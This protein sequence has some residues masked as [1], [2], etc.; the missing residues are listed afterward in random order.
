M[1]T[2]GQILVETLIQSGIKQIYG[3]PGV[4]LDWLYNAL[5]DYRDQ[6]RTIHARHEQGAAYMALGH[7]LATGEVSA[8]NVVPGPGL[9]NASAALATA[10]GLN[11]KVMCI[12]GQVPLKHHNKGRGMLHELWCQTEILQGLT[13]WCCKVESAAH[14]AQQMQQA[15]WNLNNG[16]PVPVG[17]EVFPEALSETADYVAPASL[18]KQELADAKIDEAVELISQSNRS[19]IFVGGGAVDASEELLEFAEHI[20]APVFSYRTGKGIVPDSH[21]LGHCLPA[22]HKLWKECDLCILVGSH[23]RMPLMKWGRDENL[24]ILS[25]NIDENAHTVITE[26]DSCLTGDCQSILKLLNEEL[27]LAFPERPSIKGEMLNLKESWKKQIEYLEPQLSYL[28]VIRDV[29]PQDGILVDDL[30]QM[31]F[32]SRMA[33]TCDRPRTYLSTGY[34]GTLGWGFQAAL[35]AKA[36]KPEVPVI[37]LTGDG[38]FMFGVQELAT[39]VQHKINVIVLLF[40]NQSYGNVQQMQLND[41]SGRVIASDLMNPDFVKLAESFGAKAF[42]VHNPTELAETLRGNIYADSP[43][44]IEVQ[45]ENNWPSTNKLK[46]L[47]KLR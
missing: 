3:V 11:A 43:V 38:G 33:W 41:Y 30:N 17:V 32:A 24:K 7:Y 16:K 22:A 45:V 21:Y 29:L 26:P 44:V 1:L 6:I 5:Y 4:Q 13:K 37:S 35:G 27:K 36:A 10:L 47:P 28:N 31:G 12:S 46:S 23:G 25:I 34:M 2:G 19:L 20:Q 39:A 14:M 9:L 8:F 42:R 18:E 40:N 15:L